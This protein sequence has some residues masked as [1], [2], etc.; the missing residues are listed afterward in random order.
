MAAIYN[1]N[2]IDIRPLLDY[3]A[4]RT[5]RIVDF[6]DAEQVTNAELLELPCDILIPAALENQIDRRK[7]AADQGQDHRR[8][9]QRADFAGSRRHLLRS[10]HHSSCRTS[11]P[12]AGGVTVSYF[13]WVQALQ[14]F[15]WTEQQ[16]NER[17]KQIMTNSFNAVYETSNIQGQH[18]DGALAYAVTS[19]AEFTQLRGIYP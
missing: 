13:E 7:R 5:G 15:P 4:Q 10:R 8:R 19:V 17:L 14:A 16:V 11:S 2:G 3:R 6:P 9:R 18:A 1:P 12:T